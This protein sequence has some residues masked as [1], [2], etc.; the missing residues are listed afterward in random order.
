MRTRYTTS[1][2]FS[3]K[4]G[5]LPNG[6]GTGGHYSF[7]PLF[8]AFCAFVVIVGVAIVAKAIS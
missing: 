3:V 4:L 1:D 8:K 5:H 7:H 2:R 6:D